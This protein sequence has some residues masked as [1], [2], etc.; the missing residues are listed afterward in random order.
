MTE[1]FKTVSTHTKYKV[2]NNGRVINAK[3]K[4]KAPVNLRDGYL[5]VDLYRNGERSSK[6]IHRL[7]AEAFIPNPYNKP[8][9]NHK[10]GDKHNNH[11]DNLEW[12]DKSEN[13]RH[14]SANGLLHPN[15]LRGD[16][17]PRPMLGRKNPNAALKRRAKVKIIETGEVFDSIKDC[18]IAINGSDRRICDCLHGISSSYKGHHFERV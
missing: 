15:P 1:K 7:V 8:D 4:E 13:M 18:S 2:S 11:A 5:K 10:D 14:A 3:G 12:V 6:R 17:H 16:N 9:V